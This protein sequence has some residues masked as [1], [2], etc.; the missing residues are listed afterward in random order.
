MMTKPLPLIGV[1]LLAVLVSACG[2]MGMTAPQNRGAPQPTA[3]RLSIV[4]AGNGAPALV[5]DQEPLVI[6][7]EA[8]ASKPVVDERNGKSGVAIV[9][10]LDP[11]SGWEFLPD[12]GIVFEAPPQ[13]PDEI[14]KRYDIARYIRFDSAEGLIYGCR[15]LD[16]TSQFR[17]LTGPDV[18]STLKDLKY[19]V[20]V[21][22][23][24]NPNQQITL[25]P[26]LW[27]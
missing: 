18:S 11:A 23:K 7:R 21:R 10:S 1:S 9:W 8:L 16:N 25:D 24:A 2:Q 27:R 4:S 14:A 3:P 5:L 17:C 12:A 22:S 13:V 20:R 15:R 26:R 6:T 19:T